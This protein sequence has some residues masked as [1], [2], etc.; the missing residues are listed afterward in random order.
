MKA[1][2]QGIDKGAHYL[3]WIT[4]TGLIVSEE[5]YVDTLGGHRPFLSASEARRLIDE[6]LLRRTLG[7]L[8]REGVLVFL[9]KR[10]LADVD[11]PSRGLHPNTGLYT[12]PEHWAEALAQRGKRHIID[13]QLSALGDAQGKILKK[14]DA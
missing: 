10:D 12:T 8:A 1:I 14:Y 9:V 11:W 5:P 4:V 7:D 13:M 3:T 2:H 6:T